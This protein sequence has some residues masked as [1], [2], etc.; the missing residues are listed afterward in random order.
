MLGNREWLCLFQYGAEKEWE[1]P[2]LVDERCTIQNASGR[3]TRV[4]SELL[5]VTIKDAKKDKQ[6]ETHKQAGRKTRFGEQPTLCP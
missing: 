6:K 2:I 1:P 5:N 3:R 4:D